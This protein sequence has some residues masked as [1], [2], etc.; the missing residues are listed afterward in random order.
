MNLSLFSN[1][2]LKNNDYYEIFGKS[3]WEEIKTDYLKKCINCNKIYPE[4]EIYILNH[5]ETY[6]EECVKKEV[7]QQTN[8]LIVL[9]EF[10]KS[11]LILFN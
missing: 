4:K 8:N 11:K 2:L 3:F 10:E 5:T 6:C 1:F 9:N 7:N